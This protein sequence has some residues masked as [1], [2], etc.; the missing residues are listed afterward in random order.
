MRS[1][2]HCNKKHECSSAFPGLAKYLYSTVQYYMYA[3]TP[4]LYSTCTV[5][6]TVL[7]SC[8]VL[9]EIRTVVPW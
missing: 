6:T 2:D 9:S 7:V 4:T 5:H 3:S 1:F 8:T